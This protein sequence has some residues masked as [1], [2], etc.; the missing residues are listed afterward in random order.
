MRSRLVIF[1]YFSEAVKAWEGGDANGRTTFQCV[2]VWRASM[3]VRGVSS[4]RAV[5]LSS[6]R[7]ARRI[8]FSVEVRKVAFSGRGTRRKNEVRARRIVKR[9]SIMKTL[10]QSETDRGD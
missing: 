4:C 10:V 5:G 1:S 6:E 9:P 2:M 3:M 8:V 7:R